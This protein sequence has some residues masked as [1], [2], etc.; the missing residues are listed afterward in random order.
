LSKCKND[1]KIPKIILAHDFSWDFVL[2]SKSLKTPS[3]KIVV[4]V[5]LQIAL[6]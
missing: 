6:F 4:I 3:V 5:I 1:G 2:N